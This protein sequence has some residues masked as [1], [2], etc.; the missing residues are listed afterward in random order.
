MNDDDTNN[1]TDKTVPANSVPH[2]SSGMYHQGDP[3]LQSGMMLP[4]QAPGILGMIGKYSVI[5]V[6]GEG[7]MGQVLLA[8]EPVTDS[9]V[10]I[11]LIKPEFLNKGWAV[12]RFLTEAR[13]MFRMSHG[14]I[15][16]V[17]DVSDRAEGPY[18]VMPFMAGGSLADKIKPG[19]P[20]QPET[21]L[22]VA[23]AV[24][25]ALQHAHTRGITHRDLKP[26]NILLD[27]DGS[28]HLADFGLLRTFLN[29]TII[30][31]GQPQ[32]E[33]T[34]PYMSPAVAAGK[35]EDT[36]CDIYAFGCLLYEML[37]GQPP[38]QGPTVD[39]VLKQIQDGPPPPIRQLNP[40]APA[41]LSAIAD[42]AM[43]R[44][45]RER[46][47]SM[48]DVVAELERVAQGKSLVG[49]HGREK[50]SGGNRKA[51]I[52]AGAVVLLGLMAFGISRLD[53][54]HEDK[55]PVV[56][57]APNPQQN[58]NGSP[59][60]HVE[61]DFSYTVKDGAVTIVRYTGPG[62]DVTI[63]D[64]IKDMPVTEIG[65]QA[66]FGC[67]VSG[68]AIPDGVSSIG[69][70]AFR[71]CAS[72][73]KVTIPKSVISIGSKAFQR[74]PKLIEI[75]VDAANPAYSSE[76]GI[77]FN[78]EKTSLVFCPGGKGGN[79]LIP[80]S[81][82]SIADFAFVECTLTGVTIPAGITLIGNQF[83]GSSDLTEVAVDGA[84][85]AFSTM[86][87]VLLN[88]DK[89]AIILYPQGKPGN[90]LIPDSVTRICQSA[91]EGCS[92]LTDVTIPSSVTSV[93]TRA[94][95]GCYNLTA[96][97]FRGNP[98]R[99]GKDIL[100]GVNAKATVYYQAGTKG[101]G[102]EF[103]GRPTAVWDGEAQP[104]TPPALWDG[105]FG[106][107]IKD[108]A[109]TIVKYTGT[110][111][112]LRIPEEI[113]GMPVTGIAW[114]GVQDCTTLTRVTIPASITSLSGRSFGGCAHLTSVVVDPA[115]P[116]F[117][118]GPDGIVFDKARRCLVLFPEGKVGNYAIPE[119]TTSIGS[120]ALHGCGKLTGITIP[121]SLVELSGSWA[122]ASCSS[123]VSIEVD[124]A[125]PTFSSTG[126]VL[127]NKAKTILVRYPA[128][129]TG[130]YVIPDTVTSISVPSAFIDCA[131]LTHL[132]VPGGISSIPDYTFQRCT[133][134][135]K[136]FFK[137]DAPICGDRAFFGATNA[138]I[139]HLPT[140]KGW[141]KEFGGRPT[142]VWEQKPDAPLVEGP[143]SYTVKDGA[144]TIVK[145]TGPG[146]EVV[147]PE[148]LGG[149]PV[150]EIGQKAFLACVKM[151]R[152]ALPSG[153][154][155]L[156]DNAFESCSG[157]TH[158]EIPSTVTDIGNLAFYRCNALTQITIPTSVTRIGDGAFACTGVRSVTIPNMV[159][160]IGTRAFF[161]C[162]SLADILIANSVT[163][164]G[165]QAFLDCIKLTRVTIPAS[166]TAIVPGLFNGCSALVEIKV[167]EA[168]PVYCSV[169]GVLIDKKNSILFQCP[170]GKAG[171]Y[172]IPEGVT[173]ISRGAF[174]NCTKLT[175]ITIPDSVTSIGSGAFAGCKGLSSIHIPAS[176]SNIEI[177]AFP[178]C[179]ALTAI[180]VDAAN[181]FYSSVEGALFNK[182]KT[183]LIRCPGGKAGDFEMPET[184]TEIGDRAFSNCDKLMSIKVA[185]A[186]PS[187]SSSADG[188]LFN[189]DKTKLVRC[190]PGK[191]GS[192][193]VPDGVT[194]ID[195]W[196]FGDCTKLTDITIPDSVSQICVYAFSG[197]SLLNRVEIGKGLQSIGQRAFNACVRLSWVI[198][199]GDA[200][201]I[202]ADVY[203]FFSSNA[204]Q[205]TVC[206][207]SET[208]GWGKTFADRPTALWDAKLRYC[209]TTNQNAVT[210][211]K[212]IGPGGDVSIPE[213]IGGLPV[214][215][216]AESAFQ[217]CATLTSLTVP[218][219]IKSI[220]GRAFDGCTGLTKVT[221]PASV[222][223]LGTYLGGQ[224]NPFVNCP[225]LAFITVAA[226]NPA[227]Q[228]NADGILFNKEMSSL[229]A[230]PGGKAGSYTIPDSVTSI[231]L[232]AF[233]GCAG[234]TEVKIHRGV[235][236]LGPRSGGRYLTNPFSNCPKLTAIA[237][238]AANA[239]FSSDASGVVFT[240][241]KSALL[242]Y[243][244]GRAGAYAVPDG[245]T[246]IGES[247]FA[248]C[249]RLSTVTLPASVTSIG[250]VAFMN[251][252]D[253]TGIF[254]KGNAPGVASNTFQGADKATIYY[255]PTT[256][257][258][259][260]EFGGR[261]TA[262]WTQSETAR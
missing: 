33:G 164:I 206:Y 184:V 250:G 245:V 262:V 92:S 221:L 49:T 98:P 222:T 144:V 153:L 119:G 240:K 235:T 168:N 198:L 105:P 163:S 60:T 118:T 1:N 207:L 68:I 103:G 94:F 93:E 149:L 55:P 165:G 127:F 7:G 257:G 142:K 25:E 117:S 217:N 181:P 85:P 209:Y 87:G 260:K 169:D 259:G 203:M 232:A 20:L 131:E 2:V 107:T 115:N 113:K 43:A 167:D 229:L 241:D 255:L 160:S 73:T 91:F 51:M 63:P 47:A 32:M 133:S 215:S 17:L 197:C 205:I 171:T 72:L 200:P 213:K 194:S 189:K 223:S 102:K 130:S 48:G 187:Y 95:R 185:A 36:R 126:G 156:G 125:N 23:R 191:A 231:G 14:S 178:G 151:T 34:V 252:S 140:A 139:Y 109:V 106:Y 249:P 111:A 121:K 175:G 124:A 110:A 238:D 86:D 201:D 19:E 190:P 150:T 31:A 195:N 243:P 11:K 247:A 219:G 97:H 225:R 193:A 84:N 114:M 80:K 256:T 22:P 224:W 75:T 89:S 79:Y 237:V 192:Y 78:K 57:P 46:Y 216:I 246:S 226:E 228:S 254:F 135:E 204:K 148:K 30:D 82:S 100:E 180:T 61:G 143:F 157:L 141:G 18:F 39:A 96:I 64:K 90:Y 261:P 174:A 147:V 244:S 45:L 236:A 101:W 173:T 186:N 29:D 242:C 177:D 108:G 16:R 120:W 239:A 62:G 162:T 15:I 138:T 218:E 154:I 8:R 230:Y 152:V 172:K 27:S 5:R 76:D 199:S 37:T 137:G 248:F 208:K 258:W 220:M 74:T 182:Q 35:A 28:A 58:D 214:V 26:S 99:L 129:K 65:N 71:N 159:T 234:L 38:Y 179:I 202:D 116:A 83:S 24:A 59:E 132:T 158:V 56:Q 183:V 10:A 53:W 136:A 50:R 210:L 196:A 212:Y 251:S 77:V 3:L 211:T 188:V 9:L 176:V 122:L 123:L 166:V 104:A 134:L 40:H 41:A 4:P 21:I 12:H 6:L 81:V 170:E 128:G 155:R 44:E 145:Y 66:F 69:G 233:E 42:H 52:A 112:D 67:G 54:K 227:F 146:G 13:H 70:W 161:G 253:L 88:K